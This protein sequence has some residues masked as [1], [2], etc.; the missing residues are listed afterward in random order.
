VSSIAAMILGIC[1]AWF[2]VARSSD[3]LAAIGSVASLG[4]VPL[5]A[6]LGL[7][8][9]GV[10]NRGFQAR[11]AHRLLAV[12]ARLVPMIELSASSYATNKVVKSGGAAGV[13]PFVTDARRRGVSGARVCAA[14]VSMKLTETLSMCALIAAAV[15][16]SLALGGLAGAVLYGAVASLAYALIVSLAILVLASHRGLA[17]AVGCRMQRVARFVRARLHRPQPT[18]GLSIGHELMDAVGHLRADPGAAGPLFFTAVAGKFIGIACL[19]L[20]F[21]GFGIKVGFV[22][23]VLIYMLTVMAAMVGPLPG[24]IGVA[25]ASLAGLLVARGVAAPTAAAAVMAFRL[26]DLWLPVVA[27]VLGGLSHSRRTAGERGA[28]RH[29][30]ERDGAPALAPVAIPVSA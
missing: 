27:G 8:I 6:G 29:G 23:T 4:P 17:E 20:V 5:L 25:E 1:G 11:A 22:A 12:P 9:L 3:L 26:L 21:A 15:L 2:V 18:P 16:A 7:V 10:L 13:L 14:Y 28:P 19:A 30:C 24:G